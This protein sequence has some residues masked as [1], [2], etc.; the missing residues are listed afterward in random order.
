[1]S[2]ICKNL[3]HLRVKSLSHILS[4]DQKKS[5][6]KKVAACFAP[7]AALEGSGL[8]NTQPVYPTFADMLYRRKRWA[9][10]IGACQGLFTF[11]PTAAKIQTNNTTHLLFMFC[12]FSVLGFR[13]KRYARMSGLWPSSTTV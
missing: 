3:S 11:E 1:M 7:K 9:Q 6:L 5:R 2:H 10:P 12:A 13:D 8:F 4:P